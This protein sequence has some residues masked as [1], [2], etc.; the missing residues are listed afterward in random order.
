MDN[1]INSFP[2]CDDGGYYYGKFYVYSSLSSDEGNVCT[3]GQVQTAKERGWKAYYYGCDDYGIER[4]QE[5]E[6]SD[7]TPTT[8][9]SI[10][11]EADKD[12]PVYNL[13]GERLTA[14]QKGVNIIGGR[15]VVV[16]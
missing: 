3:K 14:P 9:D 5:Y 16:K 8:V 10:R 6:G 13:R 11:T 15:K 2:I 4:W 12:A 1:L 7:D